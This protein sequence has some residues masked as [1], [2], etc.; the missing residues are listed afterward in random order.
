MA[1]KASE[2]LNFARLLGIEVNKAAKVKDMTRAEFET[3]LK[4]ER[5]RIEKEMSELEPPK[6]NPR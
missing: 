1:N 3:F 5:A 4:T 2:L 6:R